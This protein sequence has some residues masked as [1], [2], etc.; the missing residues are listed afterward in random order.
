M[1]VFDI[2]WDLRNIFRFLIF[3]QVKPMLLIKALIHLY[4]LKKW[5]VIRF[6]RVIFILRLV[7]F[8]GTIVARLSVAFCNHVVQPNFSWLELWLSLKLVFINFSVML[9]LLSEIVFSVESVVEAFWFL[10]FD[11]VWWQ[12]GRYEYG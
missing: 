8:D 2:I 6:Y 1:R 12:N 11:F 3:D 5:L 7:G 10:L 9:L 4:L